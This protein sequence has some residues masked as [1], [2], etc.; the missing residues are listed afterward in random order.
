MALAVQVGGGE[1]SEATEL[2]S[3]V[4]DELLVIRIRE[5]D[6]SAIHLS[7]EANHLVVAVLVDS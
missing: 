1:T 5:R 7:V 4:V 2:A 3:A 6:T